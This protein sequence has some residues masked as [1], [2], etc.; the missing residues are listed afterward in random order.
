MATTAR[1]TPGPTTSRWPAPA[2]A[3]AGAAAVLWVLTAV[4]E[5]VGSEGDWSLTYGAY[6]LA[7]ILASALTATSA[8]LA[9]RRERASIAVV[10]GAVVVGLGVLAS[11]LT[12]WAVPVWTALFALGYLVLA[13]APGPFR[14]P[15]L[16][17][18]G[19]QGLGFAIA[20]AGHV[21]ELG[22]ADDY[23]DH[24]AAT[25]WGVAATAALTCVG[26]WLLVRRRRAGPA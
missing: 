16:V 24:P 2:P 1:P 10:V 13:V 20:M 9:A 23:G 22:D 21:L 19:A 11:F 14:A 7:L 26:L 3:P 25:T 8:V 18:A 5:V 15:L 4:A 12:A 6:A 17:L